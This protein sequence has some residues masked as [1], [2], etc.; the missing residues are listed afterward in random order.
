MR[1][2]GKRVI[3]TGASS[4]I[5]R[6]LAVSLAEKGAVLTIAARRYDRLEE[7]AE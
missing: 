1:I 7:I 3:I 5:G 6:A 2:S 4:G